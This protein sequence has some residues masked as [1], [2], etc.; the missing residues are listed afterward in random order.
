MSERFPDARIVISVATK[1]HNLTT[2]VRQLNPILK[3]ILEGRGGGLIPPGDKVSE[4]F[5]RLTFSQ[6]PK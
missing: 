2:G 3:G 1:N 6:T 4:N 5:G